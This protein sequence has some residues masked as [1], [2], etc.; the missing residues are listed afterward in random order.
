M[1]EYSDMIARIEEAVMVYQ[2]ENTPPH[3][4]TA[5]CVTVR[6]CM[7][8]AA[9]IFGLEANACAS[10]IGGDC[11]GIEKYVSR[12]AAPVPMRDLAIASV[13]KKLR[14]TGLE[15]ATKPI[16]CAE[17]D[18]YLSDG[19]YV[20]TC[21]ICLPGAGDGVNIPV[22]AQVYISVC[23][24]MPVCSGRDA[25]YAGL[26]ALKSYDAESRGSKMLIVNP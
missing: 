7:E 2:S 13:H 20:Q 8:D 15:S 10:H 5:I 6:P 17:V 9:R 1:L 23:D 14:E 3:N 21:A 25:A 18:P 11:G 16:I 19:S 4:E 12:R 26:Q 24:L 22:W